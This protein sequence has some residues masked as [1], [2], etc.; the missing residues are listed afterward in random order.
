M[1]PMGGN[2]SP[3]PSFGAMAGTMPTPN[4]PSPWQKAAMAMQAVNAFKAAGAM[5]PG[6][7]GA[8]PT[9]V[10]LQAGMDAQ[11]TAG[12]TPAG[13]ALAMAARCAGHAEQRIQYTQQCRDLQPHFRR[14]LIFSLSTNRV[15]QI[16]VEFR[17]AE[18]A[19]HPGFRG[20]PAISGSGT[21]KIRPAP[22][23]PARPT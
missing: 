12:A 18:F 13:G 6:V 17:S 20:I 21:S 11:G 3:Q 2:M 5:S 9:G 1:D 8:G 19:P 7:Q 15:T 22:A 16:R 23:R 10:G 14:S 4:M